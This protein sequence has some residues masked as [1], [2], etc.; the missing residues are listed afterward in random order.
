MTDARTRRRI[1]G[2]ALFVLLAGMVLFVRLLPLA[3]GKIILPGPDLLVCLCFAWVLRRP[4][5]VPAPLIAAVFFTCDILL[6]QPPGLW[7][8]FVILGSEAL[9]KRAARWRDQAFV[10]EWARIAAL[11]GL[12]TVGARVMMGLVFVP[13][14]ALGQVMMQYLATVLCYPVVVGVGWAFLGLR[15]PEPV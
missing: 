6:M 2:M 13:L 7:T 9:R 5:Q 8:F 15:H 4:E 3:P 12:M 1:L 10:F 11:L 14:P